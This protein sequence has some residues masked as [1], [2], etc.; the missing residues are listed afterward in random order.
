MVD[1]ASSLDLSL[2][3]VDSTIDSASRLE[4]SLFSV[5]SIVDPTSRLELLSD[6]PLLY[7]HCLP[8]YPQIRT[9]DELFFYLHLCVC[10]WLLPP[11]ADSLSALPVS[12]IHPSPGLICSV[13]FFCLCRLLSCSSF[14]R[15]GLYCHTEFVAFSLLP[16]SPIC[17]LLSPLL[18]HPPTCPLRL[19]FAVR[20]R[21]RSLFSGYSSLYSIVVSGN[22]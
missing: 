11:F 10:R 4:L 18:D 5:D 13:L 14:S 21:L 12:L 9:T 16:R 1:S 15:F 17:S 6:L 2:F 20:R 8:L 19:L 3:P 22:C 7:H